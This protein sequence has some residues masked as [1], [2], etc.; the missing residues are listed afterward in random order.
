MARY[1]VT[2][3]SGWIGRHVL[4]DLIANGH[5][6]LGLARND[7][8]AARVE[9]TGA[10]VLR[11]DLDDLGSLRAGAEQADGVIHLAYKHDFSQIA[12]AAASDRAAIDTYASVLENT[13]KPLVIASGTLGV[14]H[15]GGGPAVETDPA[16]EI[17]GFDRPLNALATLALADRGI[18]SA[19]VRLPPTVH[20]TGDKGFVPYII[21][22]AREHGVS[23]YVG[24]GANRWPAA[25][26]TDAARLFRL[27]ADGAQPG[28][29]LHAVHDTG[30]P[31]REIATVIG[32]HLD[33]P[34]ESIPADRAADH[35]AWMAGF[36]GF[37]NP[38]SSEQTRNTYNWT[39]TGPDLLTDLDA[40]H[41][42]ATAAV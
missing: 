6:V 38:M 10:D 15:P 12:A 36:I 16:P 30:V 20:G 5:S 32:R 34:V 22:C 1:F 37:D 27:A 24:D 3:A 29:V 33:L 42:F 39:P 4:P 40:G 8:G 23:A 17:P 18:R 7:E 21:G 31:I 14:T 25:H 19:V 11:G 9:A 13:G 41:Y 2:G 26:V 28:S 35:F